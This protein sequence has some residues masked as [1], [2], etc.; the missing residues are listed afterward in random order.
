MTKQIQKFEQKQSLSMTTSMHQSINILQMSN[1]ELSA[2]AAAELGKN[3]FIEDDSTPAET[4]TKNQ[5][6]QEKF[7]SN[8]SRNNNSYSS[9]DFLENI[10]KEVTLKEHI[11]EQI[12][13]SFDDNKHILIANYL[14]DYLQ[15]NGYLNVDLNEVATNL[16]CDLIVVEEVLKT[17]QTFDPAG[18]FARNLKECLLLQLSEQ[19]NVSQ[20]L[21]KMVQNIDL[22]ASGNLKKLSKLCNVDISDLGNLIKQIKLL[23]P[24]PANGFLVEQTSYKI[25]DVILTIL[26]NG[27]LKLEI[28]EGAM[29]KLKVNHEYYI[30]IKDGVVAKDEKEFIKNEIESATTIVKGIEQRAITI[31][32]VAKAI[33]ENQIDFFTRGV[34]FLKPMTLNTIAVITGF[35]ESTVSRSTSNKYIATPS[36]IYELKYFFSSS[37]SSTRAVGDDISSTKAKEIIRQIV[38]SEDPDAILSDDDITEQL[39]KF[40]ISIARRTVAKY[41]EALD[42]PTS[43]V[44]KRNRAISGNNG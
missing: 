36:G 29:P 38:L 37:L 22:I 26:E 23:N 43:A 12:N 1:L 7:T 40:N 39:G 11:I 16:K 4:K 24:K 41:R 18:I 8:T 6:I 9:Q 14:L 25:P 10:V 3:P 44:R 35:N 28:N 15:S 42:I 13:I 27:E 34:M 5:D 30:K 31:I 21:L 20:A 32:K 2:F 17:L 33:V 19:P